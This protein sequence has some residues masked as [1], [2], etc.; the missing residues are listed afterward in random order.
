M[1]V[2]CKNYQ[3]NNESDN[4]SK[5]ARLYGYLENR[6]G[7]RE[8]MLN[9]LMTITSGSHRFFSKEYR[10]TTL[11]ALEA[12]HSIDNTDNFFSGL[13]LSMSN[14]K[15]NMHLGLHQKERDYIKMAKEQHK[16]KRIQEMFNRQ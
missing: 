7:D 1:L 5:T 2:L 14:T 16:L 11:R 9:V 10:P 3:R 12:D 6:T 4:L 15:R 8:W 13:P